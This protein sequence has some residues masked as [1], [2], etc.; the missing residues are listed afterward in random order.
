MSPIH[1]ARLELVVLLLLVHERR[2]LHRRHRQLRRPVR[3]ADRLVDVGEHLVQLAHHLLC[4]GVGPGADDAGLAQQRQEHVVR[5]SVEARQRVTEAVQ[6]LHEE[7]AHHHL[8]DITTATVSSPPTETPAP[9][10]P[11]WA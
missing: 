6:I 9:E 4:E 1:D 7:V 11:A 5:Q 10:Q 2:R 3:L 8:I